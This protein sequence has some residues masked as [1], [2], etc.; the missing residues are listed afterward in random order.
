MRYWVL[1]ELDLRGFGAGL[2]DLA[3]YSAESMAAVLL[4]RKFDMGKE[5]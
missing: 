5:D 2:C 4:I 3:G 1:G